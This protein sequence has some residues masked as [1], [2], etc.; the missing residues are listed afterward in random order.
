MITLIFTVARLSAF[1]FRRKQNFSHSE[2]VLR[3]IIDE[4]HAIACSV[5]CT[6]NYVTYTV[7]KRTHD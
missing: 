7:L 3:W 2:K 1:P 5:Q 4:L 6:D